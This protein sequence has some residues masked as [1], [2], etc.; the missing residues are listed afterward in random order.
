MKNSIKL[1]ISLA[2]CQLAGV[3]GS[4]FTSKSVSTWYTTISKPSFNPPNWLFAPVWISLFLLMGVSL[5]LVW[6]KDNKGLIIFFIQ[7]F[8]NI[9]WS[10]AF[11]GL[12]SPLFGFIIIIV[13]WILILLTIIRFFKISKLAGWLLI[14]YILWVSFA[15]ILNFSIWIIN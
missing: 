3:I 13:L 7:L 11:F 12:K 1:L 2:I 8:F 6:K 14:P 15:S 4:V 10:I 9:L 5:F